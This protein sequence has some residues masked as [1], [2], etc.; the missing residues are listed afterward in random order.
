M[1]H[2]GADCGRLTLR[3]PGEHNVQNAL[4]ALAAGHELGL[5]FEVMIAALADFRGAERRFDVLGEEAGI[6]VV[7]DY[8]HHPTEI[9]ATLEAAR[10]FNRRVIV[11][12]QPHQYSRTVT[13]LDE[14][15]ESLSLAD[16]VVLTEI[17]AA[18]EEPMPG[19]SSSM[20]G[21]V[22][23]SR[24]PEKEVI[25]IAD[26]E[27][28]A[29]TLLPRLQSGDLVIVMGAGDIRPAGEELVSPGQLRKPPPAP[30]SQEGRGGTPLLT[31]EGLGEVSG[32]AA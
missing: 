11:V 29:E 17:F 8:A 30:P 22:I 16:V 15:A 2:A 14:F 31:K 10:A 3:V 1:V 9:R 23:R 7:D 18:R 12:Y 27:A 5:S 28:V 32:G 4:A 6:M 26:K 19:V 20:I 24:H 13:F 21:D 25:F